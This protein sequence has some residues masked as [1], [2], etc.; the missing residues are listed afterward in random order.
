MLSLEEK[1]RYSR[2]II[3]D[4]VGEKGQL[5]LKQA[6][7]LIVGA[8]GLGA[9]LIQYLAAAG[10]GTIGIV[11]H[12]KVEDSNLQRQV[13]FTTN[14]IG[15]YKAEVAKERVQAQN[16]FIKVKTYITQFT[17]E[18]ALEIAK[19]YD[20][21][22]DG[23]DNFPTRYL[24]NDCCVIL[25]IPNAYASI[26]KFEGQVTVFN[27][28]KEDGTF[29]ANYRDLYPVPPAAGS[30]PSCSEAGVMGVL[31][32]IIGALQANEVIKIILQKDGVLA[33]RLLHLNSATLDQMILQYSRYPDLEP[34]T[35][36]IDY[37]EFCGVSTVQVESIS[38]EELVSLI[39]SKEEIQLIDVRTEEEH[40]VGNYGGLNIPLN[41]FEL[42]IDELDPEM[43]TIIY[44]KSGARARVAADMLLE[45][46]FRIMSVVE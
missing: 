34:I 7:V 18:N 26:F 14:D 39:N 17:S 9:P 37:H 23:T 29:T 33:E 11:D 22:A 6:K 4:E 1:Q 24:V 31:P 19:D 27:L 45:Q 40:A 13:L 46:E 12:D 20:I 3:L 8:G 21:I 28:E 36:L 44:C 30:V 5:L 41:E 42:H 2:H 43:R 32:G 25:G 16:P 10:V 35:E 38:F 15:R